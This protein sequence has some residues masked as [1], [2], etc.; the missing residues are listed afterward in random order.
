MQ[1]WRAGTT[2]ILK[3]K[4]SENLSWNFG[5]QPIPRAAPRVTPRIGLSHKEGRECHSESCSKNAPEFRELLREWPFHSK[6]IFFKIGVVPG[7]LSKILES[8]QATSFRT[9]HESM[10]GMSAK[11][12][13]KVCSGTTA[14]QLWRRCPQSGTKTNSPKRK[15]R[16][17]HPADVP[18]SPGP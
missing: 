17:G 9:S 2:P 7:F 11:N 4:R 13:R 10:H 14:G 15:F 3:K 6:S 1:L 16:A 18:G 12:A 5:V 8:R